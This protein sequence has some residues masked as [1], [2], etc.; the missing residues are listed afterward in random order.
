MPTPIHGV[1]PVVGQVV[2]NR[3]QEIRR[4]VG[5][6]TS[7]PSTHIA[8]LN[9]WID[10]PVFGNCLAMD[11]GAGDDL[12]RWAGREHLQEQNHRC[13]LHGEGRDCPKPIDKTIVG[14]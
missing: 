6:P 14:P 9:G 4:R 10:G 12:P 3:W 5:T 13:S 7:G 1:V 2:D 11:V 8:G